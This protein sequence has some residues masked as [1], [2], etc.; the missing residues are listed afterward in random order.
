SMNER[1]RTLFT[2]ARSVSVVPGCTV[3]ALAIADSTGT[4][5]PSRLGE[6]SI[7]VL[8]KR[9]LTGRSNAAVTAC[10]AASEARP[11]IATPAS[12]T[13]AG[14]APGTVPVVVGAGVVV[15]DVVVSTGCDES[16]ST[17]AAKRPAASRTKRRGG[18]RF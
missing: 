9:R 3:S 1:T 18:R 17:V 4:D 13:P 16:A 6:T 14:T 5:T 10:A 12:V 15:V 11:P 8:S 2:V 7:L